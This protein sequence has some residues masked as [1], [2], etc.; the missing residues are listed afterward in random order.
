MSRLQTLHATGRHFAV[1]LGMVAAFASNTSSAA[2]IA[3]WTFEAPNIPSDASAVAVYPNSIAPAVGSGSAGGA[4][5]AAGTVWSTP[6]GNGSSESFSANTWAVGDYFQFSTST[7]GFFD[8]TLAWDQ[9][10]SNTGPRDFKLAYSTDGVNFADIAS[11]GV[12][13]NASP[14]T[15]WNPTTANA[16]FGINQDLTAISALDNQPSVAFRLI[17]TS[18]VSA[19]G[20]SLATAGT[21]RIDNFAVSATPV[22]EPQTYAMLLAGLGIVAYRLAR[23]RGHHKR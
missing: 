14:N 9:A 16:S 21:G 23:R 17:V 11:Y 12:L 4:H 22:P 8:V 5:A 7:L 2:T 1:A 3:S 6:S 15:P 10:S 20:G 13:A 19:N 18:N